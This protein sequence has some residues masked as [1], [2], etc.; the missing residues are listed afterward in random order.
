MSERI[1]GNAKLIRK[2]YLIW[3]KFSF[4]VFLLFDK[5]SQKHF[6]LYVQRSGAVMIYLNFHALV[7]DLERKSN[8]NHFN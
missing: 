6:C 1:P 4:L 8:F 2:F 3:K 7:E 5:L